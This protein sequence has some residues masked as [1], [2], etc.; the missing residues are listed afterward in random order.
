ME[1][2]SGQNLPR[3]DNRE[4]G[5]VIDPYVEVKI[6]GHQDD[7]SNPSNTQQ[8]KPVRNN[9]LNPSWRESFEFVLTAPDLAVI[10]FKVSSIA[11]IY[12][13]PKISYVAQH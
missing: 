3:P 11:W 8:T 9:G 6:W 12:I 10:E 1:V 2:L 5:E 4:A 7:T 13:L